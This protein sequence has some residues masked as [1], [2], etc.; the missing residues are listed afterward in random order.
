MRDIADILDQEDAESHPAKLETLRKR[1]A[2]MAA[3]VVDPVDRIYDICIDGKGDKL[4]RIAA[5]LDGNE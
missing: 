3:R 1:R 2:A 4:T 5:V